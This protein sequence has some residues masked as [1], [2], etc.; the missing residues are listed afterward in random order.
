VPISVN[1]GTAATIHDSDAATDSN[2]RR[3]DQRRA[4]SVSAPGRPT[5]RDRVL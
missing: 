2:P 1:K 5:R 4:H 3:V